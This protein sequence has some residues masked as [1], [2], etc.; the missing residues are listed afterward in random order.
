MAGIMFLPKRLQVWVLLLAAALVAAETTSSAQPPPLDIPQ[1]ALAGRL[2]Q[3]YIDQIDLRC[4]Y[5][6]D[7]LANTT[8]IKDVT[9]ASEGILNDYRRYDNIEYRYSF[10]NRAA[11]ILTL[12]LGGGLK[13][14]DPLLQVKEINVAMALSRMPQV[15]ILPA[16]EKMLT[17]SNPGVRYLAWQGYR[18][19]RA[20]LL[21]QGAGV[22]DKM[23]QT[24]E[25]AAGKETSAP[26]VAVL[27]STLSISTFAAEMPDITTRENQRRAL[28]I[29]RTNWRQWCQ[30]VMNGDVEMSNAFEKGIKAL[31]TLAPS[32]ESDPAGR[33]A[34]LQLIVDL[35]R[36]SAQA[37]DTAGGK[38]QGAD[39]NEA[40]L[41]NCETALI[42]ISKT[43]KAHVSA[44][45]S[46]PEAGRGAAVQMGVLSWA[47]DL[48][49]LGVTK[50][51]FT[52]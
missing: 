16:L 41:R 33:T 27:F 39:E 22:A 10:A 11:G 13:Q 40:L 6:R 28:A 23:F 15:T 50:P 12:L 17:Y 26:V 48:K 3:Q 51:D 5:W 1:A 2:T 47:Q 20:L 29:L 8:D 35:M 52:R 4:R 49:D 25:A 38:G 18:G 31:Q 36:C 45:L 44:A 7:M 46:G 14:D 9:K 21:S 32:V 42:D 34:I 43:R 19:A 24:M 37:Y 30:R